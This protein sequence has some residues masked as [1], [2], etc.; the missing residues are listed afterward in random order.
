M[1]EKLN[2]IKVNKCFGY[3]KIGSLEFIWDLE[4][5]DWNLI[6]RIES[7]SFFQFLNLLL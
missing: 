5:D 4:F 3:L 1:T 2:S 6:Y 7:T